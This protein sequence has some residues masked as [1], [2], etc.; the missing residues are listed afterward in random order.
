MR[1]DDLTHRRVAVAVTPADLASAICETADQ[2]ES[3]VLEP[4]TTWP[5]DWDGRLEDARYLV[6][7][8]TGLLSDLERELTRVRAEQLS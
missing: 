6:A 8:I 3:V 2:F 7:G 4:I 5:S 1:Q